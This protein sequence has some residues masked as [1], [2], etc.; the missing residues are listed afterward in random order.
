M[1]SYTAEV[2]DG[3]IRAETPSYLDATVDESTRTAVLVVGDRHGSALVK[4]GL[5]FTAASELMI[6][7]NT[8][9]H[10]L[11][12]HPDDSAQLAT[13]PY[14]DLRIRHAG[15]PTVSAFNARIR[16]WT[17]SLDAMSFTWRTGQ[18]DHTIP[19]CVSHRQ[20]NFR[21]LPIISDVQLACLWLLSR[22]PH[23]STSEYAA[24][25]S[26]SWTTRGTGN[27]FYQLSRHG[28]VQVLDSRRPRRWALTRLGANLAAYVI[29]PTQ[30]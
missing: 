26:A 24:M 10:R 29:L 22:E 21:G 30:V 16:C 6:W 5:D 27:A 19:A 25:G 9:I 20:E 12:T 11:M 4:L 28:L 23:L 17:C 1:D 3:W 2:R 18:E 15:V 8:N 7:L 14:A 13:V